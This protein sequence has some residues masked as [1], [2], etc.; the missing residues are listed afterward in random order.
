[1]PATLTALIGSVAAIAIYVVVES[2]I[3]ALFRDSLAEQQVLSRLEPH[4]LLAA[5]G[6]TLLF[7]LAAS[8]A[9]AVRAAG[10]SPSEGLRDE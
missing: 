4:H 7:S 3:N 1:M 8:L 6:V 9:A 5:A 10:V 2:L